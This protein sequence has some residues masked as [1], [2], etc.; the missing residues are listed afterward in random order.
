LGYDKA[1]S[2]R[3]VSPAQA[4]ERFGAFGA[5]YLPD[6]GGAAFADSITLVNV[7]QHVLHYYFG[8]EIPASADRLYFSM[9]ETPFSF[10]E[11]D[12]NSYVPLP[13]PDGSGH[14]SE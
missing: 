7:F 13:G 11:F 6:G 9:D 3:E 1:A 5:Y 4:R 2:A 14:H 10:V 12:R 8:A